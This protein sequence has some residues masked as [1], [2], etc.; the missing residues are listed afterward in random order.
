[1]YLLEAGEGGSI[2]IREGDRF[3]IPAG[4]I[5]ISLS[6]TSTGVLFRPGLKFLLKQLFYSGQPRDVN[7]IPQLL[8][9]YQKVADHILE[10]SELLKDTDIDSEAGASKAWDLLQKNTDTREWYALLL[11]TF[12]K[13]LE[14]S[15]AGNDQGKAVWAM[16]HAATA[17]AMT[18]AAE[19]MFEQTLW[20]GYLANRVVYEAAVAASRTPAEAEAIK[21]LEPAFAGLDERTLYAWVHSGE[22]IGPKLGVKLL[23]EGLLK[24]LANWHLSLFE[25]VALTRHALK[26]TNASSENFGSN[27]PPLALLPAG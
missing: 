11:G 27:G 7:D 13:I 24:A 20:R 5:K 4:F 8:E 25:R 1:M 26:M 17:H 16:Y 23:S 14:E 12:V 6:S 9:R 2:Q 3:T 21:K 18:V 10:Q 15:I 19:G 22:S